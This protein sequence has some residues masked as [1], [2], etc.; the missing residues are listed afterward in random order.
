LLLTDGANVAINYF[1]SSG[2]GSAAKQG[3]WRQRIPLCGD[4]NDKTA[5]TRWLKKPSLNLAASMSVGQ[6]GL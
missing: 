6:H 5:L 1:A 2:A 4:L 3:S